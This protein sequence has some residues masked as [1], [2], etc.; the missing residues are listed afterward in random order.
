MCPPTHLSNQKAPAGETRMT[1]WI[2]RQIHFNWHYW[3]PVIG[4]AVVATLICHRYWPDSHWVKFTWY[5]WWVTLVSIPPLVVWG[6]LF[7]LAVL[8]GLDDYSARKYGE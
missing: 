5:I 3:L 2:K 8:V 1:D 4:W 6:F 7:I